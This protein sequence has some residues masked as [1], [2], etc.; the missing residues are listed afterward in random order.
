MKYKFLVLIISSLILGCDQTSDTSNTED[1]SNDKA[2]V[3]GGNSSNTKE[4]LLSCSLPP[5]EIKVMKDSTIIADSKAVAI[6][7]VY[8]NV[9][10]TH[11]GTGYCAGYSWVINYAGINYEV[12]QIGCFPESNSPPKNATA[13]LMVGGEI[14]DYGYGPTLQNGSPFW[15]Y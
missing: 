3:L 7:Q 14:V 12:S 1:F 9:E 6:P 10:G 5:L 4:I 8:E 13:R 11:G 2:A 15:C